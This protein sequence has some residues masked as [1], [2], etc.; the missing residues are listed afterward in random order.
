[1]NGRVKSHYANSVFGVGTV[2]LETTIDENGKPL[3]SYKCWASMIARCYSANY[4][5]KSPSY[6]G[7]SVSKSWLT[8]GNFKKFYDA[9][10]YKIEGQKTCLD[11]DILVK[12][13]KIYSEETCVFAPSN[14]NALFVKCNSHRNLLP[15]GCCYD[16]TYDKYQSQC[17]NSSKGLQYL[18]MF[19][20]PIEAFNAYK[21][22]KEDF[23]KE[24]A[25]MY[26]GQIPN[27]L[28]IAMMN[29]IVEIM[30]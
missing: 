4:Q 8:F 2:E 27:N 3:N 7:C 10:Y 18:G 6:I 22:Y 17:N 19:N 28:Y 16:T 29:Y 12:G 20:T 11:K 14:I 30:D 21:V 24:M 13:N 23:I 15:I 5:A 25:N 1:M 26:K 9:N